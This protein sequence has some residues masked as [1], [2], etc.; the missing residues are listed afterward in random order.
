M[1]Y[2][3][4]LPFI[5]N[6]N[7][8]VVTNKLYQPLV[9]NELTELPEENILCEPSRNNTAPC[10]A[11]AALHIHARSKNSSFAVLASD[12]IILQEAKFL[13]ALAKVF[14]YAETH[15][16]IMTLSIPPSRPDTGY[17]YIEIS[18]DVAEIKKV[19]SFKEKPD[20]STAELY[21]S[22]GN[23]AWNSGMFIWKTSTIIDAFKKYA[24]DIY[25][26][27]TQESHRYYTNTEQDYIDEVYPATRDISIDYAIIE[28]ADNVYT[29]LAAFGWSDLGTWASLYDFSNKNENNN[30]IIGNGNFVLNE[31]SGCL[32]KSKE[33][34][35]ILVRGLKD[36]II[37]DEEEALLLYP[38]NKEQDIKADQKKF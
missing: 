23:Y 35:K 25:D 36:Y 17:G 26:M 1:T 37:V 15:D 9:K 16:T 4:I 14:E 2:E 10:V 3:R 8:I 31:S 32:I 6:E 20:L 27:L 29:L 13:E 5:K 28:K 30:V 21:L 34:K 12:H 22:T 18:D 19:K 38:I 7:I 11:Y 24:V 33:G